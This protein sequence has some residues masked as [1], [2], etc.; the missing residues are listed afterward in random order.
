[1]PRYRN[2]RIGRD[3]VVRAEPGACAPARLARRQ[4]DHGGS[5]GA[6]FAWERGAMACLMRGVVVRHTC[7]HVPCT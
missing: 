5:W 4:A 3:R 2:R 7:V 1:M 6:F